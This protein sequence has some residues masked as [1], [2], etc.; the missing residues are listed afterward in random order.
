MHRSFGITRAAI[1]LAQGIVLYFLDA[2]FEA[3]TWPATDALVFAPLVLVSVFVPT[4]AVA[5]IGNLRPR[6]FA[7][8]TVA[9]TVILAGLGAYDILRDPGGAVDIFQALLN[10]TRPRGVPSI[11]LWLIV[12]V[13]LFIAQALIVSGDADRKFM[14]GYGRYFDIAWKHGVQIVLAALFL[15]AFWLLLWL[16][17]AIF[18][19]INIDVL[20]EL[21]A[22]RWFALPASTFVIACAILITDVQAGIVRGVRTLTLTLL[23]WLMPL[24]AAMT[25]AFLA[26]LV[27]TGLEPLLSTRRATAVLLFAGAA[28]VLLLNAAYQD[29]PGEQQVARILRYAGTATAV[30][31]TPL[32]AIAAYAVALRVEQYGWTPERVVAVACVVFAACYALGYLLAALKSPQWLK[33]IEPT[34]ILAAF[35]VL[36][37]MLALLSPMADPARIAVADQVARLESGRI[38]PEKFDYQFLRF[39]S[40]RYGVEALARLRAKQDGPDAARIAE[41][42]NAIWCRT[43]AAWMLAPERMVETAAYPAC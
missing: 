17:A 33:W 29:G 10:G 13:G 28:L 38:S 3:K 8:W 18:K 35:V 21:I 39:R 40:G 9:A 12:P 7:I 11:T 5:A 23:S 37:V 14:A 22:K 32:V 24:M 42:A 34:N 16:G 36:A 15:G 4:V 1:G 41:R 31:L 20:A 19:L 43:V 6:N 25:V 30:A 27:F 2:A 26:A